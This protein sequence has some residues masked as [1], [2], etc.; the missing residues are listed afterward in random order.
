M[1]P[2]KMYIADSGARKILRAN[3]DGSSLEQVVAGL[4]EPVGIAVHEEAGHVY[5][6]DAGRRK[7][8]R[9]N[10]NG[11]GIEDLVTLG[12]GSLAG[13]ALDTVAGKMYWADSAIHLHRIQ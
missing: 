9:A 8:Q 13:I 7:I 4:A 3:L 1:R 12:D 11:T 6:T 5:W 10:L 2:G